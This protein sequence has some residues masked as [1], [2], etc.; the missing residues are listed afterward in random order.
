MVALSDL[1]EK[2]NS[3]YTNDS[4][5]ILTPTFGFRQIIHETTHISSN[6]F[7]CTNLIFTPQSNLVT[8]SCVH[9]SLHADCHQQITYVKFN[10]K[11]YLSTS[12]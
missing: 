7:S 9:F 12:F 10:L 3:W 8:E 5:G 4:S 1:H 11:R 2:S 6:S